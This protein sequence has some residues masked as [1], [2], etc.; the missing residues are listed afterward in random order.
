M[1]LL[2]FFGVIIPCTVP[3]KTALTGSPLLVA[4][5]T[6]LLLILMLGSI[7]EGLVP[8]RN[9]TMPLCTGQGNFPLLL[10][11]L[12]A[13]SFASAFKAKVDSRVLSTLFPEALLDFANIQTT[14]DISNFNKQYDVNLTLPQGA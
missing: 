1:V 13:S 3:S 10:V 12:A 6:P 11:K 7:G 9:L 8:K 14:E 4:I 5:R 2:P